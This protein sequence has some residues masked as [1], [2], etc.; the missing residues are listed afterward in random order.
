M[1]TDLVIIGGDCS[2]CYSVYFCKI[3]FEGVLK[4]KDYLKLVYSYF[5]TSFSSEETSFMDACLV[6]MKLGL[7]IV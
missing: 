2:S 5:A 3:S 1:K 6:K 7:A 4:V